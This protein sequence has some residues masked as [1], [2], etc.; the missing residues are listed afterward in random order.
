MYG[1]V[2]D[3]IKMYYAIRLEFKVT[4]NKAEYEVVV[5]GLAIAKASRAKEV[6]MKADSQV[7]VGQ[8]IG[9][10]LA[11]GKRL[12]RNLQQVYEGHAF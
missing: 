7:I 4:N 6:N 8:I 9:K 2:K 12:K 10:Y 5:A 11:K 3:N 1:V